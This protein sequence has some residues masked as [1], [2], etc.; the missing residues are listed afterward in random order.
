MSHPPPTPSLALAS[1][2]TSRPFRRHL[3]GA[4]SPLTAIAIRLTGADLRL[5][6]DVHRIPSQTL[7]RF[8]SVLLLRFQLARMHL[9]TFNV[10]LQLLE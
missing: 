2:P 7:Q 10:I 5:L 8:L 4:F 3:S 9:I 6:P 1:L